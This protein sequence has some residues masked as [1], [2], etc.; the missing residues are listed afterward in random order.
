VVISFY[1]R[2]YLLLHKVLWKRLCSSFYSAGFVY[3]KLDPHA[4]ISQ[5]NWVIEKYF[6]HQISTKAW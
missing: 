5:M 2:A 4:F 1:K 3:Q 6:R